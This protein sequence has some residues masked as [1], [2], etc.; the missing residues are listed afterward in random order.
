MFL[1]AKAE[2]NPL[3]LMPVHVLIEVLKSAM[4]RPRKKGEGGGG[5]VQL[6]SSFVS[7][8]TSRL[9]L[10]LLLPLLMLLVG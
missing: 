1:L 6:V 8:F 9:A 3:G 5:G 2:L 7:S 4:W 10:L